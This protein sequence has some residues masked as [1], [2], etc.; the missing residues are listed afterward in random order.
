LPSSPDREGGKLHKIIEI[1]PLPWER[2]WGEV[3]LNGRKQDMN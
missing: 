1:A 3:I 2:G